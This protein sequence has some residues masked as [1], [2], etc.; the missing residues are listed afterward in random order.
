M[1]VPGNPVKRAVLF[2][3][4]G[5]NEGIEYNFRSHLSEPELN[6]GLAGAKVVVAGD[7]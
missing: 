4:V 5:Q 7:E 1:Q 3:F 6:R 2:W